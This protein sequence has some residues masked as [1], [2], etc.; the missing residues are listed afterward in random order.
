[1]G[2]L[3]PA[4]SERADVCTSGLHPNR[5]IG[6]SGMPP[7]E[8]E[9]IGL[10]GSILGWH[11]V[12]EGA[13]IASDRQSSGRHA[14]SFSDSAN[15]GA[16]FAPSIAEPAADTEGPAQQQAS[17]PVAAPFAI[18]A[19]YADRPAW[20]DPAPP[21]LLLRFS[22][23]LIQVEVNDAALAAQLARQGLDRLV[24]PLS[25]HALEELLAFAG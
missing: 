16:A 4:A 24:L 7:R 11:V 21:R 6:L 14:V 23:G 20:A 18:T 15:A 8:A 5:L 3:S 19:A 25:L 22:A 9:I 17:W 13:D 12:C 10:M 2:I 1:M